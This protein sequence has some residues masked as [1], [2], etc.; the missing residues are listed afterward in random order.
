MKIN[1]LF[2]PLLWAFTLL[3]PVLG[4][5]QRITD[6]DN[7]FNY[8]QGSSFDFSRGAGLHGYHVKASAVQP[9]GKIIIG[10]SFTDFNGVQTNNICRINQDGSL[11]NSFYSGTGFTGGDVMVIKLLP[12]GSI[13]VGGS[14]TAYNGVNRNC[15]ARL[16]SNG[17]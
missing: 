7:S 3:M 15:I 2:Q 1:Y 12:N 13:M 10:G 8:G 14:F 16:S 9:D 6:R 5:G 4:W 11:D 17:Y